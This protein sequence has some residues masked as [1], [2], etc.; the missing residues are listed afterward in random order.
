[1][2]DTIYVWL[3]NWR[4]TLN[5]KKSKVVHFGPK[6]VKQVE[7]N[8]HCGPTDIDLAKTFTSCFTSTTTLLSAPNQQAK[9]YQLFYVRQEILGDWVLPHI[10]KLFHTG[11]ASILY[12][13]SGV[14]G[15]KKPTCTG[16]LGYYGLNGTRK[17][18]PSYAKSVVYI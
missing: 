13:G 8:F 17:I 15:D 5:G 1:M 10:P 7:H 16:E 9:H 11:I 2:M 12:Y 6:S 14:W 4:L 3:K 18:G